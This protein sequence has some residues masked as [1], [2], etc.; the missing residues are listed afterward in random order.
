MKN[1]TMFLI[2]QPIFISNVCRFIKKLATFLMN[3]AWFIN[4]VRSFSKNLPMFVMNGGLL[5][6][7]VETN[8]S[9]IALITLMRSFDINNLRL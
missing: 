4:F 1:L 6:I 5:A 7:E 2:N 9:S 3:G 8:R